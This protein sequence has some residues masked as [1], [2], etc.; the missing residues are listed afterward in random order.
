MK[1][2]ECERPSLD[3]SHLPLGCC[4]GRSCFGDKMNLGDRM[5][6]G[7]ELEEN[8]GGEVGSFW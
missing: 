2:N 7:D 1:A 3:R 6:L 4:G 5:N 8:L